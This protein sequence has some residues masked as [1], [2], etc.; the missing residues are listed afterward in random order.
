MKRAGC[1]IFV[2][3]ALF[4][5]GDHR[6][7]D[8]ADTPTFAAS[9]DPD[10]S[11]PPVPSTC[12]GTR[13][14]SRDFRKVVDGCDDSIALEECAPENG[15]GNGRCVAAC[16]AASDSTMGCEFVALPPPLLYLTIGSCFAVVLANTWQVP[17]RI[18]AFYGDD[19]LDVS[20]AARLVRTDGRTTTYEPF[21][22]EL[23]PGEM[24][25]LFL[26]ERATAANAV[27]CPVGTT[28]AIRKETADR[29]NL[30]S[31]VFRIK[32]TAPLSAYSFYPFGS[33]NQTGTATLLIPRGSWKDDYS[34]I[35]P[36][37]YRH[38]V[39]DD[40][41]PTMQIVAGED[42][43]D[44]SIVGSVQIQGGGD[45]PSAEK[46]TPTTYRL[47][48]GEQLQFSQ[49]ADLTGTRI[50][51]NKPI[52]VWVGHEMFA[53]P[54]DATGAGDQSQTALLPVK[55]WGSEYVL[56]PYRS[57]RANELSED[58]I[59][60]IS[61]A[62]DGTDLT[63]EPIRPVDAPPSISAGESVT[64]TTQ[65][66]FVV[67]SQDRDHP[68][69][70]H[71]YMSGAQFPVPTGALG[72]PEFMT[73]VPSEQYLGR[74][75]FWVD[76]SFPNSHLVVVRAREEGKDFKPVTLDCAGPLDDWT[77]VGTSGKYEYTRPWLLKAGQAQ[78]VGTGTCSGGRREITSDG[79]VAVTVWGMGN[80]S[81]YG[82][83]GGAGLR[84]LNAVVPI[85]K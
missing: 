13:R 58:Y 65:E 70:V 51:A 9:D 78:P 41:L 18:E 73:V 35:A 56:V 25:A 81:S 74:Y 15:C 21:D 54:T 6:G 85:V 3:G 16:D 44:V 43:T 31:P 32:A 20:S 49:L 27:P 22:G 67:K 55:S 45:V 61:G 39:T 76:P 62:V 71:S 75:V 53:V 12:E 28:A 29:G 72:D 46:G 59:Y 83:P 30:R 2:L 24:A 52:G 50:G 66:P 34:V 14:C 19:A 77:P 60:R 63:Y 40:Y 11:V 69:M 82:Y 79:P 84:E 37:H 57:R 42:D 17:S 38:Y 64:F 47:S 23:A 48:A 1:A 10:G 80:F 68:F 7:F 8:E 4:A 36:W 5:C 26:S 33:S